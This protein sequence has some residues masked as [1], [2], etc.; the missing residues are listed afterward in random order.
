MSQQQRPPDEGGGAAAAMVPVCPLPPDLVM[1]VAE[2]IGMYE[3]HTQHEPSPFLDLFGLDYYTHIRS[4]QAW[5][6][7]QP[8][9]SPIHSIQ[10]VARAAKRGHPLHRTWLVPVVVTMRRPTIET[11][12]VQYGCRRSTRLHMTLRP[13][14]NDMPMWH[15]LQH[16]I[17]ATLWPSSDCRY[18]LVSVS[19]SKGRWGEVQVPVADGTIPPLLIESCRQDQPEEDKN[20]QAMWKAPDDWT[21]DGTYDD[22]ITQPAGVWP[23]RGRKVLAVMHHGTRYVVGQTLDR[24]VLTCL[25]ASSR[26][27]MFGLYPS[28]HT[29]LPCHGNR[30]V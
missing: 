26:K 24:V 20:I 5:F 17:C 7:H 18:W 22:P 29:L 25:G 27:P 9:A 23:L 8:R 3:P 2:Y 11:L 13:D 19:L 28:F 10:K 4:V 12:F 30:R 1:I 6:A 21:D 15:A 16:A 14:K